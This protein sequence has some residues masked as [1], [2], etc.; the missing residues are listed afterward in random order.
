MVNPPEKL[1]TNYCVLLEKLPKNYCVLLEK[2]PKNY[3]VLLEKSDILKQG[4]AFAT[5]FKTVETT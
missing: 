5:G 4:I 3:C 2:L 1:S